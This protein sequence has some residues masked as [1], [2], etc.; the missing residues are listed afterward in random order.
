[1]YLVNENIEISWAVPAI[2]YWAVHIKCSSVVIYMATSEHLHFR[3]V[4]AAHE[5]TVKQ[6]NQYQVCIS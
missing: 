1:M 4:C 6:I 5:I 3:Q 2:K